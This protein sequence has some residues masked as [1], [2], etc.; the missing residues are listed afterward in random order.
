MRRLQLLRSCS[1]A[2]MLLLSVLLSGVVFVILLKM[3][4]DALNGKR[5][6]S[7][8][9]CN[10]QA[11]ASA[12]IPPRANARMGRV[13]HD[14]IKSGRRLFCRGRRLSKWVRLRKSHTTR[15]DDFPGASLR[16]T[17][18][19]GIKPAP[20]THASVYNDSLRCCSS[21]DD[22]RQGKLALLLPRKLKDTAA[23]AGLRIQL[24]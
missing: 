18:S 8:S 22:R 3:V 23:S 10:L 17:W 4:E 2:L 7:K 1:N 19:S 9:I 11:R 20:H 6:R 14:W 21:N 13:G 16:R 15:K 5:E 24:N 12:I